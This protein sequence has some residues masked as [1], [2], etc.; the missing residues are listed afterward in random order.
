MNMKKKIL[1]AEDDL[2]IAFTLNMILDNAGYEVTVTSSGKYILDSHYDYP[3]LFILDKRMPDI[4][5]L[6]VCR[7]L[8]NRQECKNI[9]VIIISASPNFGPLAMNAGANDF[10]EKPFQMNDL[11]QMVEKYV[12]GDQKNNLQTID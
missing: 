7:Q 12:N 10:I 5:G 3:D 8:R 11:L 6:E 2:D 4:D 9:P 1:I